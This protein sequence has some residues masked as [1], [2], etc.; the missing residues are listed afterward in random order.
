MFQK[1]LK[2]TPVVHE[3]SG[4]YLIIAIAS[5]LYGLHVVTLQKD[6][7]FVRGLK[8]KHI[9]YHVFGIKTHS[10]SIKVFPPDTVDWENR[11]SL[12]SVEKQTVI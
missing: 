3:L 4:K 12:G 10:F 8:K 5:E 7:L 2:F 1:F 11:T 9:K 6:W